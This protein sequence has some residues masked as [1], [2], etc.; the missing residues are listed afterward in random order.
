VT[1]TDIDGE[2]VSLSVSNLP[3]G[4]TAAD[5]SGIGTAATTFTWTPA[6]AQVGSYSVGFYGTDVDG[7]TTVTVNITV[8][9]GS[10]TTDLLISEY[11]EGSSNNKYI[12]IFNGTGGS[13]DL[14]DYALLLFSNGSATPS[15]SNTL[16]GTLANGAVKVYQNSSATLYAGEDNSSVAFNGD[17]AVSLYKLSSAAYVDIFGCIGEDPGSEWTSGALSTLNQTLVRKSTVASGITA[18]PGSGFPT[19][20]TEWDTYAQDT[21]SDLGTHTFSGG[22]SPAPDPEISDITSPTNGV[23]MSMQ[24]DTEV[25][26]TYA[27][28]CTSN[29]MATSPVWLQ[30]DSE[31]GT[32]SPVI[33]EDADS[34]AVMRYYR[35]VKP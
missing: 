23:P 22:G 5:D 18:N 9:D 19:L 6:E 31:P 1:A 13:V 21:I 25:G 12:E 3:S 11:V 30:V 33:L 32:G 34:D 4:A 10:A 27:L 20:G 8:G 29:L 35:V 16:S 15:I 2:A 26:T 17:D 28:Q 7:T 14:S 24:I